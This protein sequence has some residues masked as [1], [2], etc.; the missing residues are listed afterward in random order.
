M[1]LTRAL[2]LCSP[3]PSC[4]HEEIFQRTVVAAAAIYSNLLP[5]AISDDTE[6]TSAPTSQTT[7]SSSSAQVPQT[8]SE[9]IP[10]TDKLGTEAV[11]TPHALEDFSSVKSIMSSPS[12]LWND[13][14]SIQ[15]SYMA[16]SGEPFLVPYE[17]ISIPLFSLSLMLSNSSLSYHSAVVYIPS[18]FSL[19]CYRSMNS[20][21][22]C[23]HSIDM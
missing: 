20:F 22:V 15:S 6:T 14:S 9:H 5:R 7:S 19:S 21:L 11:Y 16:V 2:S 13:L 23:L 4:L 10:I 1:P 18:T 3:Y 17:V 12:A 8:S